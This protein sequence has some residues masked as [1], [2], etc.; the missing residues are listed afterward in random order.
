MAW[1][2]YM[3]S[4]LRRPVRQGAR[5]V[6]GLSWAGT[7]GLSI[8]SLQDPLHRKLWSHLQLTMLV[9][10]EHQIARKLNVS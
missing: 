3:S 1:H 6:G 7:A 8:P 2:F 5:L 4:E 10:T 9:P